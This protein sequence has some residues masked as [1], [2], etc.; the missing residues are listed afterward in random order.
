MKTEKEIKEKIDELKLDVIFGKDIN[1][2]ED[3]EDYK[4][5]IAGIVLLEWVLEK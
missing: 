2:F 1:N 4:I 3:F 5:K